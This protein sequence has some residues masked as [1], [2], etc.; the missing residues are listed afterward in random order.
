[1]TCAHR[2]ENIGL[3]M[4]TIGVRTGTAGHM[5]SLITTLCTSAKFFLSHTRVMDIRVFLCVHI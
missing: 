3:Y 4:L 2:T 1:M 5:Y